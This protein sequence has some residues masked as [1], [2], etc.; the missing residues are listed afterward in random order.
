MT[1]R[2]PAPRALSRFV[3]S[4]LALSSVL[5]LPTLVHAQSSDASAAARQAD[6]LQRQLQEQIQRDREAATRAQPAPEGADLKALSPKPDASSAGQGCHTIDTITID[7]A[8]LMPGADQARLTAR[9]QGQCLGAS[10]IEQLL[11]EITKFYIDRGHV[12]TRAYLPAQDL[13][14]GKLQLLVI[15]GTIEKLTLEDGAQRSVNLST[16]FPAEGQLLNL[17][18]LEQGIDQVNQLASN[19]A[20]LDL[21]PGSRP[22]T[23]VVMIKNVPQKPWRLNVSADNQGT[24]S[25]GETQLGVSLA[26]DNLFQL[27]DALLLTHRRSLPNDRS[28]KYSASDSLNLVVP[29]GY[30]TASMSA[31]RSVYVSAFQ[32]ASGNELQSRGNSEA[33]S[34]TLERVIHRDQDSRLSLG[35]TLSRKSSH[36]YLDNQFLAVSSRALSVMD[37]DAS[38]W[39]ATRWGVMQHTLTY[40]QGLSRGNALKDPS[41]L[42]EDAPKAQFSKWGLTVNYTLPFEVGGQRLSWNTSLT[43]QASNDVLYGSEQMLIGGHYTVRG[44]VN[45]TLSGDEGFYVRN[46][47]SW[48]THLPL[49]NDRR[50]MRLFLGLDHGRVNNKVDG[51]PQGALT[52]VAFGASVNWPWWSLELSASRPLQ[53]PSFLANEPTYLWV[54][55]NFSF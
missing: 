34:G 7:G 8:P 13:S 10:E 46:D 31:S 6:V 11:S 29:F 53:Q 12:T 35:A 26:V 21:Q 50:P 37:V 30:N 44:F 28:R 19:N 52:G 40:S 39:Q 54:R 18:D 33:I 48:F 55:L 9:W 43:G 2:R 32:A 23:S 17:R 25:T 20:T 14:K 22:G 27:N 51:I 49:Q 4:T 3:F 38:H 15:E 5:S 47:L 16:V 36:N 45:S 24:Q 42:P 41:G 1:Y